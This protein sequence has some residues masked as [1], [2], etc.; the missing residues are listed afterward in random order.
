MKL[1]DLSFIAIVALVGGGLQALSLVNKPPAMPA[2][3]HHTTVRRGARA[4]CLRRHWTETILA[5]EKQ[6]KHPAKWREA[7]ADCLLCHVPA[8]GVKRKAELDTTWKTRGD[9]EPHNLR[10]LIETIK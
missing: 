8:G 1:R 4:Q 3:I 6:R 2:D 7:D 5:L 9:F 10:W